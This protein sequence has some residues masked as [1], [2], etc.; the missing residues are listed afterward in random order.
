MSSFNKYIN[1]TDP[2][3]ALQ[4]YNNMQGLDRDGM[5]L[6]NGT[7]FMCPGD[8]VT[9]TGDLDPSPADKRMMASCGPFDFRPG[10]SQYVLIKLAVGPGSDRLS[11]ITAL[12]DILNSPSDYCADVNAS[13]NFN[14]LDITYLI[15]YLYKGGPD[16][17]PPSTG[18]ASGNGK[19][20]ALD[21]TY[22]INYL[23]KGGPAPRCL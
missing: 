2:G 7:R 13:G 1:G 10:D 3:S 6:P 23:Y 21:V 5:P 17:I 20:N 9:G 11:S 4:S 22:M 19:V 15:N 12:K 18:D 14:A 8:P 16:P